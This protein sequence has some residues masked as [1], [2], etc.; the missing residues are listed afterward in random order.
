MVYIPS[1]RY[2][3]AYR[4]I[5]DS[6]SRS[7]GTSVLIFVS[8]DVD[9]LCA[10]RILTTLL[11]RDAIAH[12]IVPVTNYSDISSMNQTLIANS[13][14]QILSVVF[15]NC[16][17]QM[18]IQD[19]LTLRDNL[20]VMIVDSHRPFNL[21]NV[22]WHEQVQCLDD[23]D[24]EANM[25]A[26][27]QAFEAIEFGEAPSD[28]DDGSDDEDADAVDSEEDLETGIGRKRGSSEM[29]GD[30]AQ[31][32]GTVRRR[33][34]QRRRVDMDPEEFLR[35]QERRAQRREERAE[36][37][38]IIQAYYAQGSYYGQSCAISA[39]AL[40]EQLG[41]PPTLDTVWW[42][43]VGATS[44]HI[45]Q[46]IDADGYSVVVGRMRDLVRRVSPISASSAP[47]SSSQRTGGGLG[48]MATATGNSGLTSDA[49]SSSQALLDSQ[50][51]GFSGADDS[52]GSHANVDL[53]NPYLDL[54]DE[55]DDEGYLR[56]RSGVSTN[57]EA[58]LLTS[59]KS[60]MQ[61]MEICESAEL[62]FTLLRHWSLDSSMRFS[63][64]VATR[65]ATWSSRGRA[66]LDL[67]LA[68]L[69]LSKAEAQA[70]YLHLAPDLKKQLYHKMAE[71]GSDYDMPDAL[72]AGFVRNY[73]WRKS[74]FS[75]SDMALA[76]L[77]LLQKDTWAAD[78]ADTQQS[79]FFAAYDALS[80]YSVLK[81]G[82]DG[83]Q[84]LQRMVVSQ[85]ISMLERQAVKT[86]RRL[87]FAILGELEVS[88]STTENTTNTHGIFSS[89]FALRQLALFLMQTLRERS[90]KSDHARRPFI[91]AAPIPTDAL[92]SEKYLVLGITPLDC[93]LIRPHRP[94]MHFNQSTFA[95]ES[96]NHFGLVFEEVA[97][98]VGAETKQG[99]FDSS[100]MEIRRE[101]MSTFVDRLRRHL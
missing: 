50:L 52:Y 4:R 63:P 18:D 17:A 81:Q 13:S 38:Q 93:S 35:I 21:Y 74:R 58:G 28:D 37:Q 95:G 36:Q 42:A 68:K 97:A 91:I 99:F 61:Q 10:L 26:L 72:Y 8:T 64:Y 56:A 87:R 88:S 6:A 92:E 22:F 90:T 85:G 70:P 80:Q 20:S 98:Q 31:R 57:A 82:I 48:G 32:D 41:Q 16:G 73:G 9:G 96:R 67:L 53:F 5:S 39:L 60:V 71:I 84:L 45:L 7:Q 78:A 30:L 75:A 59:S 66:R 86:L 12:K 79:G 47:S 65:L 101:D 100:V 34:K 77:A 46:H 14:S 40:A 29:L 33:R 24:V 69:G 51:G 11:K 94:E 83:A 3:D 15:L 1:S 54:V 44:Q 27:R 2:E 43:I 89:P 62:K 25:D 19:L 76:L 55:D 23:G 49:T